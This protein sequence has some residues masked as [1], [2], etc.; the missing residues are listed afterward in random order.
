[1]T[2]EKQV[3]EAKKKKLLSRMTRDI[4]FIVLGIIF[5]IISILVS[6][7]NSKKE[8]NSKNNITTNIK[9]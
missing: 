9:K 6:Y 1:M 8:S 3:I 5:L 4:T 2:F 7:N